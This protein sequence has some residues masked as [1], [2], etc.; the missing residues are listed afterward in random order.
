MLTKKEEKEKAKKKKEDQKKL[1]RLD[2]APFAMATEKDKNIDAIME[3]TEKMRASLEKEEEDNDG[4]IEAL[5][6]APKLDA[7]INEL[8]GKRVSPRDNQSHVSQFSEEDL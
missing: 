1:E 3:E 7:D 5:L 8:F 6:R 4:D 2:D